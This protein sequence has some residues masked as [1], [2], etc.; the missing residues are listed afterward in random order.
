M[1]TSSKLDS[2]IPGAAIMIT[3][4]LLVLDS[5]QY[6]PFHPVY[7]SIMPDSISFLV[8]PKLCRHNSPIPRCNGYMNSLEWSGG[9]ERWSGLLEWNTGLDYWRGAASQCTRAQAT[10]HLYVFSES[11]VLMLR[12]ESVL[13]LLESW[14]PIVPYRWAPRWIQYCNPR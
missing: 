14:K 12:E 3:K 6:S 5:G 1:F 8:F 7:S 10:P 2:A 4:L 11:L 13:Y 9:M